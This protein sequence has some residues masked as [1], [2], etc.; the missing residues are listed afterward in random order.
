MQLHTKRRNKLAQSKLNDLVF[1]KYNRALAR[2]FNIRDSIDPISLQDIDESNEWL[3]GILDDEHA[4]D[5]FVFED[6]DL[7]WD[8]VANATGVEELD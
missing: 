3:I 4:K 7:T 6:T 8:D 2:R 5:D 1:I